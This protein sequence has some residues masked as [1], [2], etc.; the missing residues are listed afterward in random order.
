M[1]IFF[2][3]FACQ[4]WFAEC[5]FGL[6]SDILVGSLFGIYSGHFCLW[7][8]G[9]VCWLGCCRNVYSLS[10]TYTHACT[11]LSAYFNLPK[12]KRR[13]SSLWNPWY[14]WA[15]WWPWFI[16][17]CADSGIE[18]EA[19]ETEDNAENSSEHEELFSLYSPFWKYCN[20]KANSFDFAIH[21]K[22][23]GLRSKDEGDNKTEFQLSFPN[24]YI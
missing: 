9:G 4:L 18:E 13:L 6:M 17:W 23:L 10:I 20:N 19:S 1:I 2:G 3:W 12:A 22:Y 24:I 5:I 8:N 21:W 16:T 7:E 11:T 15:R 14:H